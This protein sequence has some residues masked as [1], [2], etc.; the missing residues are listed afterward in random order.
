MLTEE[1]LLHFREDPRIV[2]VTLAGIEGISWKWIE[3]IYLNTVLEVFIWYIIQNSIQTSKPGNSRTDMV[4]IISFP[5]S[6]ET[7][8]FGAVKKVGPQ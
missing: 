1:T 4:R 2:P 5:Y 6:Q 3:L 8:L 7:G